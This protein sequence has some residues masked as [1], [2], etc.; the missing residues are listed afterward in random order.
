MGFLSVI[1]IVHRG[2]KKPIEHYH[3]WKLPASLSTAQCWSEFEPYWNQEKI[4]AK[5]V[6]WK[7]LMMRDIISFG[8]RFFFVIHIPVLVPFMPLSTLVT[9]NMTMLTHII[10]DL[11]FSL[12][13]QRRLEVNFFSPSCSSFS[14]VRSLIFLFNVTHSKGMISLACPSASMIA[15]GNFHPLFCP[16]LNPH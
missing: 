6:S 11:A 4:K 9:P 1:P 2:A 12:R 15:F 5:Y 3:L 13:L 7:D 14:T 16:P 10:P 8:G